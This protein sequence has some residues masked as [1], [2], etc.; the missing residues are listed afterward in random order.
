VP[1]EEINS[2]PAENPRTGSTCNWKNWWENKRKKRNHLNK[3]WLDLELS[4]DGTHPLEHRPRHTH[5]SKIKQE[6]QI[7]KKKE[8]QTAQNKM[9]SRFFIEIT[10]DPYNHGAHHHLS[11]TWL[12]TKNFSW[13]TLYFKK[14]K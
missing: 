6:K 2:A 14:S 5:W 8:E 3:L 12:E 10:G 13:H 7:P 9:Q 1:N 11:L 4:R